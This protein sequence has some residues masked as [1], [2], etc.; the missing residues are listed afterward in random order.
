MSYLIDATSE[1]R[2]VANLAE[3]GYGL[4]EGDGGI[5][6]GEKSRQHSSWGGTLSVENPVPTRLRVSQ[7]SR[8]G[9]MTIISVHPCDYDL[10]HRARHIRNSVAASNEL[11]QRL[12]NELVTRHELA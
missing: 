11:R 5:K 10:Q 6:L 7:R 12:S 3:G 2:Q 8:L 4:V 9:T 1:K